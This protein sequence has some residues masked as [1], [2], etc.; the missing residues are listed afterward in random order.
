MRIYVKCLITTRTGKLTWKS[1]G[2]TCTYTSEMEQYTDNLFL[3][4]YPSLYDLE[5]AIDRKGIDNEF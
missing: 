3:T 5:V 2:H 4:C 1:C